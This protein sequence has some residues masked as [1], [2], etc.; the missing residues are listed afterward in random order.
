MLN[1][2]GIIKKEIK[3]FTVFESLFVKVSEAEYSSPSN[4]VKAFWNAYSENEIDK[5]LND[6]IFSYI[7]FT[8]FAREQILPLYKKAKLSSGPNVIYD[9][10]F[11]STERGPICWSEKPASESVINRLIWNQLL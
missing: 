3:A 5:G 2:L 7:L 8:L 4:Y 1:A 10:M 9:L 6:E 11:Y